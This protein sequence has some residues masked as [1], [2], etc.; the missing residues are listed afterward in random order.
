MNHERDCH[1]VSTDSPG[2]SLEANTGNKYNFVNSPLCPDEIGP[3]DKACFEIVK[4]CNLQ[5]EIKL[6]VF[7]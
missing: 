7:K 2:F 6:G 3:F 1:N 4:S 5:Q